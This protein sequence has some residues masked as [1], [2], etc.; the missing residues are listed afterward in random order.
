MR[1]AILCAVFVGLAT[2]S[3]L[4]ADEAK[5]KEGPASLQG[6]WKVTG[7]E[8]EGKPGD[9]PVV[10]FWWIIKGDKVYYGGKVLATLTLDSTTNPPCFD[11]A[12]REG[13]HTLEGIYRLDKQ[14]LKVCVNRATGG[15]KE[16][17]N[18]FDTKGHAEWRLL[19][20]E[21]DKDRKIDDLEGLGA[22]VGIQIKKADDDS[23]ILI[24][25]AIEGSPAKAAGL[26]ENDLL[27]KVAGQDATTLR[28]TVDMIRKAKPGTDLVLRIKRG[29]KEM[30][31]TIKPMVVPFFLLD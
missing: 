18:S 21:R 31:V 14:T 7:I 20:F 9:L 16:R 4:H 26:K 15:A 27:L 12:F 10:P 13:D 19:T 22:F 30:D 29:D 17:P 11:L 8:R 25:G 1:L 23:G 28:E 3:L 6:T 2:P 5:K 24:Q